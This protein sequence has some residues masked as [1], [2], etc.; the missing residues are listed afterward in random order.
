M[1]S[2]RFCDRARKHSNS[3]STPSRILATALRGVTSP[4]TAWKHRSASANAGSAATSAASNIPCVTTRC[5]LSRRDANSASSEPPSLMSLNPARSSAPYTNAA[6]RSAVS[7]NASSSSFAQTGCARSRRSAC[8]RNRFTRADRTS[9]DVSSVSC[10]PKFRT[11]AWTDARHRAASGRAH[12]SSNAAGA[13]S[14]SSIVAR[15]VGDA[16]SMKRRCASIKP[17]RHDS[18]SRPKNADGRRA[19]APPPGDVE[20]ASSVERTPRG[21]A[22]TRSQRRRLATA[23]ANGDPEIS[24]SSAEWPRGRGSARA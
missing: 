19:A 2:P 6:R 12:R 4:G 15:F 1:T 22:Y 23:P 11:N 8:S 24:T 17:E 10:F 9:S 7:S 18:W 3:A 16:W 13:G 20:S 21:R 5:I 14:L